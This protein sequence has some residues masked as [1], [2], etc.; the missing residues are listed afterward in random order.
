MCT[1][2]WIH[3]D[4]G[5][6]L[7]CNRDERCARKP[8]LPPRLQGRGEVRF[9]APVDGEHGGSWIGVNQFGLSLC[10][11][12]RYQDRERETT[13]PMVSRGLVL[14]ELLDSSLDRPRVRE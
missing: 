4:G 14:L 3:Q 10:L 1:V 5:Y 7:L 11:L 12:N 2:S 8:A 13:E 6:Q 9:I